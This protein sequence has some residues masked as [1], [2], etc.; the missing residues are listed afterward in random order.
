MIKKWRE[1]FPQARVWGETQTQNKHEAIRGA[2][3]IPVLRRNRM[4]GI[5]EVVGGCP[6]VLFCVA[7]GN[8]KN[9]S[10]EVEEAGKIWDPNR[11]FFLISSFLLLLWSSSFFFLLLT[12]YFQ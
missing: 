3:G 8:T 10:E 12:R 4:A 5:G 2:G 9:Y 1:A 11:F 7:P 6:N